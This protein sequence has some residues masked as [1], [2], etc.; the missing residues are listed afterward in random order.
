VRPAER[1]S[2]LGG[3]A[4][5]AASPPTSPK[6]HAS[7]MS[8]HPNSAELVAGYEQKAAEAVVSRIRAWPLQPTRLQ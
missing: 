1:S 7:P 3:S 5:A 2:P 4:G 6:D 8:P